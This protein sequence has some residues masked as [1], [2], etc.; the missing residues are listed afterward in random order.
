MLNAETPRL[1]FA[2]YGAH[3]SLGNALLCELLTRQHE[4]V[5]LVDDLNSMTV[6][7]G[8]RAKTGDL[9]DAV[10]VSQSVAG[11]DAVICLYD[12]PSLATASG[13][14]A[15]HQPHDLYQAVDA[16]LSGLPKVGVERLVLVADLSAKGDD[17]NVT[18]ALQ[19]IAAHPLKWTLVDANADGDD[20]SIEDFSVID[21][22]DPSD[23][24][25]QLR[26]IAAG[27]V[28][29]LETPQHLH[30]QIHFRI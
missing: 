27:I 28:D 30:E 12:S 17:P 11:M 9:F 7:P 13:A 18:A 21:D 20:L 5:A 26:R 8:L 19:R 10:S 25:V 22:L 29:E 24:R 15:N 1:K 6:R 2:L 3:S 16:L 4:A 14:A 23:R